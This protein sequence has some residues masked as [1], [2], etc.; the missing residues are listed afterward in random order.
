MTSYR[1]RVGRDTLVSGT[2]AWAV[3]DRAGTVRQGGSAALDQAGM[4]GACELVVAA[5]LVLLERLAVPAAQQRRVAGSLRFLAEDAALPDPERLHVA[6]E[7]SPAKD[8]LGIAIVD[9]RWL[10]ELL[11]RLERAGLAPRSAVPECLLPPLEPRAWCVV[12]NGPDSF[13]RVGKVEGFA[14]DSPKPGEVP[15]ALRLAVEKAAPEKIVVRTVP[16]IVAPDARR[17]SALLGVPVEAGP[18]WRWAEAATHPGLELL[19]NEFAPRGSES[20]WRKLRRPALLAAALLAAV[21][22]GIAAEWWAK[23]REHRLLVAQTHAIYRETFGESA[24]IV[25]APLQMQRALADLRRRS[26]EASPGDF[27]PLLG[28]VSGLLDTTRQHVE[29]ITYERGTLSVV[30]RPSSPAQLAALRDELQAKVPVGGVQLRVD[31]IESQSG[32]ALRLSATIEG[33]K[34]A[35]GRP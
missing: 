23:A 32:R 27:L 3:L 14:L 9:R 19:Q 10:T 25:D 7:S 26:G 29:S 24:V 1:I 15:V 13:A 4:R 21:S 18:P 20:G 28:K 33:G 11:A 35:S 6:A 2:F 22:G 12:C 17:W 5:D 16:G 34:W 8:S 30:L 31:T